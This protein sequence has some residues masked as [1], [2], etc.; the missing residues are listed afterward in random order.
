MFNPVIYKH[1]VKNTISFQ[2]ANIEISYLQ[3]FP[4]NPR[5]ESISEELCNCR[6]ISPAKVYIQMYV[7]MF[8][9]PL[10][11]AV[12]HYTGWSPGT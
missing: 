6:T 1:L 2:S 11:P 10:L 12:L 3:L 8:F 7:R 4:R 5:S 9:V